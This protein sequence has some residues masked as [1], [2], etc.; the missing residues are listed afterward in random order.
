VFLR[1]RT[2]G[3]NVPL[4]S[5]RDG[6]YMVSVIPGDYDLHYAVEASDDVAP[7]NADAWLRAA[8]IPS[9]DEAIHVEDVN[10]AVVT[11][12]G[13]ITVGDA[14]PVDSPYEN[15]KL[16]AVDRHTGDEIPLAETRQGRY[17]VP[18]VG[19]RYDVMYSRIAG[20]SFVPVNKRARILED[21]DLAGGALDIDIPVAPV[22]GLFEV[23]G[24]AAPADPSDDGIVSLRN[25]A[26]ADIAVLGNTHDGGYDRLVVLGE[27]EVY[28]RQETAGGVLPTNT[29]ARIGTLAVTE[30]GGSNDINIPAKDVQGAITVAGSIPPTSEFS[31]GRIYLRNTETGD[32]VLL[33]NTRMAAFD[34]RVVPGRYDVVYVVETPGAG[35]PVNAAVTLATVDLD[36]VDSFDVDVPVIE[37]SGSIRVAGNAP[38]GSSEDYGQLFLENVTTADTVLLGETRN[39]VFATRVAAG[40]YVVWYRVVGSSGLVP[41]NRDAGLRCVDLVAP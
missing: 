19:M 16:V 38:S 26:T 37:L 20:G 31:D 32:A 4:G 15:G 25:P 13:A 11:A 5:T 3:D 7:A 23:N 40:R 1:N 18:L 17:A 29:S 22:S 34:A 21:V 14:E 30:F 2:T 27:Y 33:G 36:D 39:G 12:S 10:I 6:E 8:P 9:A 24:E 28:Y 41:Q 35:V